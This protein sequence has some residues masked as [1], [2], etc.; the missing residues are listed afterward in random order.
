[1]ESFFH[2]KKRKIAIELNHEPIVCS[3]TRPTVNNKIQL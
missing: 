3:H 2:F 1:M